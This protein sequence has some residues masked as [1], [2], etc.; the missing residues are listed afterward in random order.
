MKRNENCFEYVDREEATS[1]PS[2]RNWV[3]Q[4]KLERCTRNRKIGM[5]LII[6][7]IMGPS[8]PWNL[9]PICPS[10][11]LN[12]GWNDNLPSWKPNTNRS[13]LLNQCVTFS[14]RVPGR[15][16]DK[17]PS[18]PN[19]L[20]RQTAQTNQSQLAQKINSCRRGV[21]GFHLPPPKTAFV[22]GVSL[23]IVEVVIHQFRLEAELK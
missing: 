13:R 14:I 20:L 5:R 11:T 19:R 4:R 1:G 10:V 2:T 3:E 23:Q 18:N 9:A 21:I 12:F 8:G 6:R 22:A 17:F 16:R 7:Q 15:T